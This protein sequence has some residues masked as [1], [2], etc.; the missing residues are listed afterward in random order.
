[1]KRKPEDFGLQ[2]EEDTEIKLKTK[3]EKLKERRLLE[4][5]Q[6]LR[7]MFLLMKCKKGEFVTIMRG[8]KAVAAKVVKKTKGGHI[9]FE[10]ISDKKL[11][12]M[13][14]DEYMIKGT[15]YKEIS[16]EEEYDRWKEGYQTSEDC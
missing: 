15:K 11:T 7:T 16:K 9:T 5:E 1:M 14:P 13:T 6:K 2:A 4:R 10:Y 12:I 8:D 3:E